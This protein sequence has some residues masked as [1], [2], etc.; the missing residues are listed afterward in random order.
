[1]VSIRTV[2]KLFGGQTQWKRVSR[3]VVFL[4]DGQSAEFELDSS[5]AIVAGK[6]VKL[7]PQ[8]R[9]WGNDVFIPATIFVNPEFQRMVSSNIL[10]DPGRNNLT[11]DPIPDVGSPRLYSYP[12]RSEIS[13]EL[14]P[15]VNYRVLSLRNN[16]LA[17]RLYGGRAREREKVL[18][19]D[20]TVRSVEVVPRSRTTDLIVVM[21]TSAVSPSV[22]L[23]ESPRTLLIEVA[24]EKR[25]GRSSET[26]K[27]S[28]GNDSPKSSK[29]K[30]KGA[31]NGKKVSQAEKENPSSVAPPLPGVATKN[32]RPRTLPPVEATADGDDLDSDTEPTDV[33]EMFVKG[34]NVPGSKGPDGALLALSPF[35]TIVIDPGHGGKDVGAVGPNGTLEKEVNLQIGLALAKLLKK[36]GRFN[37]I[38][39]RD[40]DVFIPLQERSSIA[41]KAKADLFISLHCNAGIQ[42]DSKGFEIFY[43]SENATDD[44]AAA[45][46][47]RENAVIE[48]EGMVGKARQELEGLLWSLAR[49]EH[50]ND[51]AAIAGHISQQ[52]MRRIRIQN[53]GVKQAGFYV[54]RGTSTPAIL[55]ESA[56]ISHP[57]EEG[58]LRSSR[59]HRKLVDALYAGLLDFERKKIQMRLAKKP[60]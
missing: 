40:K 39:T 12:S 55:V 52:V 8:V 9:A 33:G 47:R 29:G 28:A 5:T 53:R 60:S 46:A 54:L 15:Y 22:T 36:E 26:V 38:L 31:E 17:I 14:G 27:A 16:T 23:E 2:N 18:V 41:N 21:S 35:R 6:F 42:R 24:N 44:E 20:G 49:N 25:L 58:M 10:W 11:I 7:S 19:E 34:T 4:Y 45:V 51:S 3:K 57:K 43:L 1:M 56:F 13:V 50:M 48:L 30:Q 37:V 32:N 59:F